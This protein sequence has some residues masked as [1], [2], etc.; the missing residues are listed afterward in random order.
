LEDYFDALDRS[1]NI[2]RR[3]EQPYEKKEDDVEI[4]NFHECVAFLD[5]I[6]KG[7]A[8][9]DH[10]IPLKDMK[11]KALGASR[12]TTEMVTRMDKRLRRRKEESSIS[13]LPSRRKRKASVTQ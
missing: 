3:I 13:G 5:L 2:E 1:A 8:E 9:H 11:M 10:Q 7:R 6:R 4:G 12:I